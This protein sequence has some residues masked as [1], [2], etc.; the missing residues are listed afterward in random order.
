MD[1]RFQVR[2]TPSA[3]S[4]EIGRLRSAKY[5]R[6]SSSNLVADATRSVARP[7][8][9]PLTSS[10]KGPRERFQHAAGHIVCVKSSVKEKRDF[11]RESFRLD[12]P[13]TGGL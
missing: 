5:L 1:A 8:D 13:I 6:I 2:V 9:F 7:V 10:A 11:E 12:K 4:G 3:A